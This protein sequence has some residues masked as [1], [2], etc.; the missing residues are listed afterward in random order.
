MLKPGEFYLPESRIS[1]YVSVPTFTPGHE[2]EFYKDGVIRY[3]LTEET[4]PEIC[5]KGKSTEKLGKLIEIR[6]R[7]EDGRPVDPD[8][9]FENRKNVPLTGCFRDLTFEKEQLDPENTVNQ[10][11]PT[12]GDQQTAIAE[13]SEALNR[14]NL[15]G[16]RRKSRRVKKRRATRRAKKRTRRSRS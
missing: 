6:A 5:K 1:K 13:R 7:S 2:Y 4:Q 14:E 10:R 12:L 9:D 11:V 16:G 15:R 8:G 3:D